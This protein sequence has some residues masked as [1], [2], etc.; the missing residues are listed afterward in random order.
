MLYAGYM[1]SY[2]FLYRCPITSHRVQGLVRGGTRST[3]DT[4][5][6][7]TVTCLACNGVHLV[8]P[9]SGRVLCADAKADGASRW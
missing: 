4:V 1:D 6:Y 9:S 8:N 3:E 7:E 2:T 5:T